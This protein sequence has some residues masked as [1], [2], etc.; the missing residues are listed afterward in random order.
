[1]VWCPVLVQSP[2]F[3]I[4]KLLFWG[5]CVHTCSSK[6]KPRVH[7]TLCSQTPMLNRAASTPYNYILVAYKY[8]HTYDPKKF[9][10]I[11]F[12]NKFPI[13][14]YLKYILWFFMRHH[15]SEKDFQAC[16]YCLGEVMRNRK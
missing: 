8:C 6:R 11:N 3:H 13:A 1:M 15:S 7:L 14:I 16:F 4:F 9:T 5:F 10:W 2:D 12:L